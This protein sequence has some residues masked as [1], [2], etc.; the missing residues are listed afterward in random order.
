[1]LL[2]RIR[3]A[4]RQAED[5]ASIGPADALVVLGARVLPD[6]PTRELQAR[7]DHACRLWH[8]HDIGVVMVSGGGVGLK[9]E[10]LVM[11]RYLL[12][13]GIPARC[14]LP[15]QPGNNTWQSLRSL[16]QLQHRYGMQRFILVS[17]GY[18]AARLLWIA[19]HFRLTVQ[20]SAPT[21]TPETLHPATLRRQ[22]WREF[23]ALWQTRIGVAIRAGNVP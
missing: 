16:A 10:V 3:A 23:I 18:H 21:S 2:N 14:I 13:Q 4:Q 1:M 11:T 12:A 20:V 8:S 19:A 7:L 5:Q 15:C 6:R 22:Q 17:S 9:D